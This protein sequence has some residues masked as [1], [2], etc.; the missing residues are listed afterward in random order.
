MKKV[1][2]IAGSDSGAGAGI[3]AD[4]KV[5]AYFGVYGTSA[6]TALTAQNTRGVEAVLEI[7]AEFVAK[8]I[9]AVMTDIG[10]NVWK[11][12][13]LANVEI[14]DTVVERV[15]F[16][17]IKSLVV[18]PVMVAKSGDSL[19]SEQAIESYINKLIPLALIIT[20]NFHEA[21]A[22]TGC[23]INNLKDMK[24]AAKIIYKMGAKNVV[25]KGGHLDKSFE[26]TDIFYN[27]IKFEKIVSPRV[28]TNN[29]HGTGCT[30]S[31]AISAQ[32]ALG[33]TVLQAIKRAKKYLDR[34]IIKG[35]NL[36]IGHG[37]GPL[38]HFP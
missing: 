6:I 9:D 30:Y 26:A 20:P 31:S 24:N 37:I 17:D 13:M 35:I 32:V 4:L 2:T 36:R 34:T 18:D 14:V 23:S 7:P 38:H 21:E 1:L 29:T 12:G 8:Q 27:G 10:A 19:L 25:V 5:F 22:I 33:F 16:Y 28:K 11:T 3:Q 15:K